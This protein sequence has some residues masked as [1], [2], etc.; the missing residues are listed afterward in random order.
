MQWGL[1]P[2]WFK[3]Y[4][5]SIAAKTLNARIETIKQKASFKHI[6]EKNHCVIPSNGFYEW[7][8]NDNEKI[9][10]Y[11]KPCKDELFS[12]AGIY[13]SWIDESNNNI[14]NSFSII[15]TKANQ[16]MTRIHNVKKRMP[17]ILKQDKIEEWISGKFL[18]PVESSIKSEEMIA[19]QVDKNLV[20]N[21]NNLIETTKEIDRS[22]TTQLKLF[23]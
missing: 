23:Q 18:D 14:I 4:K 19:Y 22:K 10:F 9:P 8:T 11:I 17:F 12:F 2:F 20:L 13:D 7:H 21:H 16:L 5:E 6:I 3:G 15:T 1:I